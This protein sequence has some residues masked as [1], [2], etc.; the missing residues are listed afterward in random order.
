MKR[1]STIL[2]VLVLFAGLLYWM[3]D[4]PR[5][6]DSVYSRP[7]PSVT[8]HASP[9]EYNRFAVETY[10]KLIQTK[11]DGNAV[12]SP[13]ALSTTL[14]ILY[15]GSSGNTSTSFE[16]LLH[17]PP[18]VARMKIPAHPALFEYKPAG[19]PLPGYL[20]YGLFPPVVL[21]GNGLWYS[22]QLSLKPDYV[23][24]MK[25]NFFLETHSVDF[26]ANWPAIVN[27]MDQWTNQVTQGLVPNVSPDISKETVLCLLGTLYF[28]AFWEHKFQHSLTK[29]GEFR[30]ISG[31]AITVETMNEEIVL[32]YYED[33]NLRILEMPYLLSNYAMMIVLPRADDGIREVEAKLD[34]DELAK[35]FAAMEK[36]LVEVSLPK[37]QLEQEN[38]LRT[39]FD[40]AIL[41]TA[42]LSEMF[43]KRSVHLGNSQAVQKIVLGIDE[44]GTT[45]AVVTEVGFLSLGSEPPRIIADHPF[46]FLI[47]DRKS[48]TI[49][50]M[51]RVM[52]PSRK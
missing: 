40:T 1:K 22:D 28:R 32:P 8:F 21:I 13:Y 45:A 3:Y 34:A 11:G 52:D 46:L 25:K 23:R 30:L 24:E 10:L 9:D 36:S 50:F 42:D 38:D 29:P 12:F 17:L 33:D 14:E 19:Q 47:R 5:S 43:D 27:E 18:S 26:S 15:A 4:R 41:D 44:H 20:T 2:A 16:N 7:L 35:M 48:G 39:L 37:F 49:L 6:D 31:E 51:G